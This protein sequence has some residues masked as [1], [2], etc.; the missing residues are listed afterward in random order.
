LISSAV[1]TRFTS[2]T[3]VGAP[4]YFEITRCSTWPSSVVATLPTL[5]PLAVAGVKPLASSDAVIGSG[6][7]SMSSA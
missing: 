2:S 4:L 5:S 1:I 7:P 3:T 6:M